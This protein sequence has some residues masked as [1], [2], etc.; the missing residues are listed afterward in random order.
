MQVIDIKQNLPS[1]DQQQVPSY[2]SSYSPN[3]KAAVTEPELFLAVLTS[4]YGLSCSKHGLSRP[5]YGLSFPQ[6]PC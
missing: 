3:V 6:V 2:S 1:T 4:E 5:D